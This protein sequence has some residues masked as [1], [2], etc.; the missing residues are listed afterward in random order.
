[1]SLPRQSAVRVELR[2]DIQLLGDALETVLREQGGRRLAESVGQIR[3]AAVAMR[4]EDYG[5]FSASL[6]GLVTGLDVETA[7]DV[8]RVFGVYF[9]LI[10]SAEELQRLRRLRQRAIEQYPRPRTG[11]IAE[12]VQRLR[13]ATAE[14]PKLTEVLDRLTIIPVIT[15]HPSEVRRRSVINHL[16]Q[17]R[18]HLAEIHSGPRAP[19]EEDALRESI[20]GEITALWQT[21]EPRPLPPTPLQEVENGLYYLRRTIYSVLP[22]LYR[23]LRDALRLHLPEAEPPRHAFLRLGSWIGGDRDGNPSVTAEVTLAAMNRQTAAVLELYEEEM[24]RLIDGL[25]QST[26]RARVSAELLDS[27]EADAA[28]LPEQGDQARREFP[29]E[30]YRQKLSLMLARL[31]LTHPTGN[32]ADGAPEVAD[33]AGYSSAD[34]ML[35]DIE[36]IQASLVEHGGRRQAQT[37]VEDLR[38]RVQAF[39]LHIAALDVRQHARVHGAA[40]ADLLASR[41]AIAD[42]LDRTEPER[43]EVLHQAMRRTADTGRTS[44]AISHETAEALRVFT[45]MRGIQ[46]RLGVEACATYIVSGT[47]DVSDLLEVLF[48]AREAALDGAGERERAQIRVVPLFEAIDSLQ[49]SPEI[50]ADLL[51]TNVYRQELDRCG[52]L[53]EIMVGYSDSNKDGG[54]LTSS[55]ELYKA[56]RAL[57]AVCARFGVELMIFHG[58]GGAIGRGG[59]PTE[60]AIA[61]EPAG[62]LNGRF[63]NTE[64]GEVVHTR[65]ANPGIAHR[66]LEQLLGAVLLASVE[67]EQDPPARWLDCLEDLSRRAHRVYRKLVYET[68]DFMTYFMEATPIREI[69][70]LRSSSRPTRRDG[71][72]GIESLRAIPWVFSWNQSRA[73]LPG[74]YGIGSALE[75][76]AHDGRLAL[77]REMY[78][79]W[80]FFTSLIDNAQ[81]SVAT[82]DI[83]TAGLYA[84]L[85]TDVRLAAH[86]LGTIALEFE[87]TER[88]LISI[89]GQERILDNNPVLRESIRLRN[90]YVDPMHAIQVHLLRELRGRNDRADDPETERLRYAVQHTINGIAAGLQS[91][92]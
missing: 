27:I 5:E 41:Y 57:P 51:Q 12:I 55:W 21:D 89:T 36:T 58:R 17:I 24:Q 61:A 69:G 81:I 9:H 83:P 91:T 59:G 4:N 31:R 92:G 2:Q 16:V 82:A 38:T 14:P 74:W 78:Q 73:N 23:E 28:L 88:A 75:E 25:S 67:A 84:T 44:P 43:R 1:M 30:P 56:K 39:G 19:W 60:S 7:I 86:V 49:R 42:Y 52:N 8:V 11:S 63:K 62:A 64:Q 37:G 79:Q 68:D 22:E 70:E 13:G 26:R 29:F 90:P 20:V 6:L 50:I 72:Q 76:P 66:H 10:N 40:V 54:Y 53:Q 35:R 34:E 47:E 77:L 46:R 32:S 87:R 15:A 85:V 33:A 65:Y 80:G 18:R 45:T 48:L 3:Q 71:G